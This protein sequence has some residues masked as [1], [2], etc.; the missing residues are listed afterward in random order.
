MRLPHHVDAVFAL[1]WRSYSSRGH[2]V[3]TSR[4]ILPLEKRELAQANLSSAPDMVRLQPAALFAKPEPDIGAT[5]EIAG[6]CII[7]TITA[8]RHNEVRQKL[9]LTSG[10]YL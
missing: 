7:R 5:V 6:V 4:H 1:G 3:Y 9:L 2:A 8:C 10:L